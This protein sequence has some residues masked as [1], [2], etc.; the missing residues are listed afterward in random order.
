MNASGEP[1]TT[2]PVCR[3][4]LTGLPKNHT[5]PECGFEYDES[6]RIWIAPKLGWILT[7]I[8]LMP[9]VLFLGMFVYFGTKVRIPAYVYAL[10]CFGALL[11]PCLLLVLTILDRRRRSFMVVSNKGLHLGDVR[12]LEFTPWNE[13][14]V[15]PPSESWLRRPIESAPLS[16]KQRFQSWLSLR[17]LTRDLGGF[18]FHRTIFKKG[19]WQKPLRLQFGSCNAKTRR[20]AYD[21]LYKRWL[22]ASI[23]D[24]LK[25]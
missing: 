9:Q 23:A 10:V 15:P 13:L 1:I 2:C 25:T 17:V 18:N 20:A 12:K 5:C 7:V 14:T 24:S 16:R 8:S 19:A 22:R 11:V 4:D 21:D 6:M 3:Y